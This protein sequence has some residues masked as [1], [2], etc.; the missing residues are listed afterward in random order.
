MKEENNETV[1]AKKKKATYFEVKMIQIN[2]STG[3]D[4]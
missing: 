1:G 4:D 3:E 2:S